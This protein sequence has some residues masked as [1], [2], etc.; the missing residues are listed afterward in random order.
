MT[1]VNRKVGA[2]KL[3]NIT[4]TNYRGNTVDIKVSMIDFNIQ[5]DI[6][7]TSMHGQIRIKD[8]N[9]FIQNLPLIGEE[10]LRI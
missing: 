9:D 8:S 4:I 3:D 10:L 5:L 1:I 7:N 2:Y 6:F